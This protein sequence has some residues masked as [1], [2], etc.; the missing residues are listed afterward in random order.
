MPI[1]RSVFL[2]GATGVAIL[3]SANGA[4]GASILSPVTVVSNSAGNFCVADDCSIERT[5]DH[6]GLVTDFISGVTDFATYLAGN[7]L[8]DF[9]FL[10]KEWFSTVSS[11]SG[12][13]VYDLGATHLITRLALW[14][15]ESEGIE[16]VSVAACGGD[17]TC[18][19]AAALGLFAV[20]DNPSDEN[21]PAQIF[22]FTDAPTRF[23]RVTFTDAPGGS[24]LLSLGELAFEATPEAVPEPTSLLLFGT[25]AVGVLVKAR[26]RKRHA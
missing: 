11:V 16:S 22:D 21:Y 7:P 20:A 24:F 4:E 5:I 26:R 6:S 9:N 23:V 18:A 25:G 10:N 2:V 1:R 17:S 14:N 12:T 19:A 8:H 15:E 3:L 13:V